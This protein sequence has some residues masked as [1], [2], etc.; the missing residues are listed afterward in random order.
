[1]PVRLTAKQVISVL[2]DNGFEL[3]GQKGFSSKMA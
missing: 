1:M 3:T 2:K